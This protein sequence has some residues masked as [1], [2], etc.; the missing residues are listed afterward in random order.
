MILGKNEWIGE[1]RPRDIF[2]FLS[3]SSFL[4][5]LRKEVINI[6]PSKN[7]SRK[8]SEPHSLLGLKKTS[9]HLT[10]TK[11]K[12]TAEFFSCLALPQPPKKT[13]QT[14]HTV[15]EHYM[16]VS[17][18]MFRDGE[19]QHLFSLNF[20]E[21]LL[22]FFLFFIPLIFSVFSDESTPFI[23][24]FFLC[25]PCSP[26]TRFRI[27]DYYLHTRAIFATPRGYSKVHVV[28]KR[29]IRT[30]NSQQSFW[31]TSSDTSTSFKFRVAT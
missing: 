24:I 7:Q 19:R 13:Q 31:G 22:T 3:F 28:Q 29:S 17:A 20:P 2:Y 30:C 8:G 15:W 4:L 12:T 10:Y 14:F 9:R 1:R 11:F 27:K 23:S 18:W 5:N 21:W 26:F 16:S 25:Q 6:G